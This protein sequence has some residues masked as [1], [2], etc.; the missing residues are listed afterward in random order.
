MPATAHN[1]F[2]CVPPTCFGCYFQP[3]SA[4]QHEMVHTAAVYHEWHVLHYCCTLIITSV[5]FKLQDNKIKWCNELNTVMNQILYLCIKICKIYEDLCIYKT[6][7][8]SV[9]E[10]QSWPTCYYLWGENVSAVVH[11]LDRVVHSIL[12]KYSTDF[13]LSR[14]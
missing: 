6:P 9:S 8:L 2:S 13:L 3:S 5:H 4:S 11:M 12:C 14:N 1:L 10:R 7:Y